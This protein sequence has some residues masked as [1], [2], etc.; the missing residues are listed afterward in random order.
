MSEKDFAFRDGPLCFFWRRRT[1]QF[2][3]KIM[4]PAQENSAEKT[5]VQGEPKRKK[6]QVFFDYPAPIFDVKKILAHILHTK[7]Y[8][9]QPKG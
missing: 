6:Y 5:I 2:P 8:H 1:R 7:P 3:N 9:P 4:I